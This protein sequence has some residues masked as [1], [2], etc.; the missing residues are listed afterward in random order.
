[1]PWELAFLPDGRI[2]VT[3][4]AG[5]VRAIVGGRLLP[6]PALTLPVSFAAGV[7]SGLLGMAVPPDYS[8]SPS[9]FLFY[10]RQTATGP[11]SRVSRFQVDDRPDGGVALTAERVLLD[12]LQGGA[13]CHFGGRLA[14]GPDGDLYATVGDGQRPARAESTSSVNGKVLRLREDGTVPTGNP[15]L[16]SPVYLY[17]LRN[18]EGLAWDSAGHLY[19]TDNGPTGEFGL[20]HHDRIDLAQPGGFYGW[21]LV[22]G[23]VRTGEAAAPGLP[24]PIG[25]VI[26][27][28]NATWAPSGATFYSPRPGEQPTLLVAELKG[29]DVLRL[30]IDPADA[31]HVLATETLLS[32]YGRIRDV[33]AGPDRCLYLLTSN[34]DGRGSPGPGDDRV[35]RACP[36]A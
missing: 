32:G 3:E 14:F 23:S 21:P 24:D 4:R 20:F 10:T 26:E 1:M 30:T 33:V 7:E 9:V 29:T 36:A 34:R 18:P 12:G 2:L 5:R 19:V 6:A 13:C 31:G 35:L 11:V 15:F 16:G 22:A 27:S 8:A 25:P 28:G 17:G